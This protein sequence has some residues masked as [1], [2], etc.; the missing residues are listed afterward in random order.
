MKSIR[1][2][3]GLEALRIVTNHPLLALEHG[4]LVLSGHKQA[5]EIEATPQVKGDKHRIETR[6]CEDIE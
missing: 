2:E 1:V 6:R 5:T 4:T 3:L